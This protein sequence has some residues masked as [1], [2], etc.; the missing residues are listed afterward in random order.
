MRLQ[1]L[2]NYA[3]IPTK[4]TKT[5]EHIRE[6]ISARD[7]EV[8]GEIVNQSS[9]SIGNYS[10]SVEGILNMDASKFGCAALETYLNISHDPISDKS[11]S[12]AMI[13]TYYATFF[14]AHACLRTIGVLVS[15]LDRSSVAV[16]HNE[17][18]SLYPASQKPFA[19]TYKVNYLKPSSELVFNQIDN[20]SGYHES[21]WGVFFNFI[22]T[23][24]NSPLRTQTTYQDEILLI[25]AIRDNLAKSSNYSWLSEIRNKINYQ[26]PSDIWYPYSAKQKIKFHG[27]FKG[28][29]LRKSSISDYKKLSSS[30]DYQKF[31]G[32][33]DAIIDLMIDI[34]TDFFQTSETMNSIHK[35]NFLRLTKI[36]KQRKHAA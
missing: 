24:L 26:L 15:R 18:S 32:T 34:V 6:I 21:F 36:F 35:Q 30:H 25:S 7:F 22:D 14:A 20:E 8:L 31:I 11:I 2:Y 4:V 1:D 10:R 5:S 27:V 16:L 29:M 9:F 23:G 13:R 17:S 12:W 28:L 33:C 3:I 19:S